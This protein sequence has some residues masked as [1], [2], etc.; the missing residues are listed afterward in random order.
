MT[1][2]IRREVGHQNNLIDS[3]RGNLQL[4][5]TRMLSALNRVKDII[6]TAKEN[7]YTVYMMITVI[8][9]I[10][11]VFIYLFIFK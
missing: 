3:I 1:G 11:V 8:V 10:F 6:K 2:E 4:A 9:I 7:N 5:S